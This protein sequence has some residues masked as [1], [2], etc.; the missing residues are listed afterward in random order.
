[1]TRNLLP[2]LLAAI[3]ALAGR[4][5]RAQASAPQSMREDCR[6]LTSAPHRLA[7]SAE[8]EQAARHVESRMR[9]IGLDH[10]IVQPF[11]TTQTRVKR[12][13]ITLADGASRQLHPMRPNAIFPPV[14][15]PEGLTA[16]IVHLRDGS[17]AEFNDHDVNGAIVVMDYNGRGW[18]RAFRLGARAIVFVREGTA[19]AEST[20]HAEVAANLPRFYYDGT[21]D[22]LP[23]A[24]TAT[25][26]SQVV[27]EGVAGHNVFGFIE[28]TDPVFHQNSD[29]LI[30]I[31]APL[32]SFG[33]VP[34]LSPGARQAA[35][36]AA[37]LQLASHF[38]ANPPRRHILLAFFDNQARCHLGVSAFYQLLEKE[39]KNSDAFLDAR[40]ESLA[41]EEA[42]L[43]QLAELLDTPD[44]LLQS[45]PIRRELLH[46][47]RDRAEE[48]AFE[49]GDQ[50]YKLRHEA[51]ECRKQA[52]A[53][54][55]EGESDQALRERI[56][57]IRD[58]IKNT[59]QP[60]K[61][62]W[63]AFRR[64]IGRDRHEE[65]AALPDNI[66]EKQN[67]ILDRIREEIRN[68]LAE[69][70]IEKGGNT[71]A[72]ALRD[73]IGEHWL[74]LHIALMLGDTTPRWGIAIGGDSG[75]HAPEDNPG[76]YGK[77]QAAF[78]RAH[79]DMVAAGSPTGHFLTESADQ[80][81]P[82]T[83]IL[84]AAPFFVHSGEVAGNF[85][86]YNIALATAQ[87]RLP[88][89]GTPDDTLDNLDLDRIADQT[90][91]IARL[92]SSVADLDEQL[93]GQSDDTGPAAPAPERPADIPP[94][95][96]DGQNASDNAYAV[97]DQ[98]GL[99]LRRGIVE[100]KQYITPTFN[101]TRTEGA[102]VAYPTSVASAPV[103][104]AIIQLRPPGAPRRNLAHRPRK[105]YAFDNFQ[106][107]RTN[108]EGFYQAGPLRGQLRW[109]RGLAAI[110]DDQGIVTHVSDQSTHTTVH[111]RLNVVPVRSGCT[112]LPPPMWADISAVG[113]I[114]LLSARDNARVAPE[115]G[116]SETHDGITSWFL[117]E[118]EKG[119]KLFNLRQLVYLGT[120]PLQLAEDQEIDPLGEGWDAGERGWEHTP[121]S[122]RSAVDLWRLNNS[123]IRIL[124]SRNIMDASL[125]E[126]HGRA[127]DLLIA[128][129]QEQ[130]P[131]RREALATSA[132]WAGQPV[133]RKIRGLFDDLVVAVLIL[134][135]ISVPFAFAVERVVIGAPTI[136][137]QIAWFAGIFIATFVILYFSHPA[138]AIAKTPIIIFL[139][140]AI[141]VLSIM[142]ITIIVRKFE[143]E[144]KALQGITGTV[145]AADVSRM[146]TLIA[147]MQ[148]GISTMRRRP[149]RTA[150]TATT[151][152]LLTFTILCFASFGTES[153]IVRLLV[154]P[155]PPYAGVLVHDVNW[156][157]LGPGLG[158]VLR[159]RWDGQA[160]VFERRWVCP[161]SETDPGTL[162]SRE[163]GSAPLAIK[164]VLGLEDGEL[165][166]RP[167]LRELVPGA[168]EGQV[169]ISRPLADA[170]EVKPGDAVLLGGHRL[171]VGPL[172][173]SVEVSAARDMDTSSILPVDFTEARSGGPTDSQTDEDPE[174]SLV[175]DTNWVSLSPDSVVIVAASLAERMGAGAYAYCLYTETVADATAIAEDIA[176]I[177]PLPIAATRSEGVYR[178]VLGTKLAASGL[179]DLF[180]PVLLGG[181]V[182]FGTMLGSVADR[183][184][185]IYTFSALGL[186]PRHVAT[187]FFAESMVYSLIGGMGGYLLAQGTLRILTSLAEYGLV[188]V[189]EMNM[190]SLNTIFTILIVMATVM[191]SA[192]YPAIKASKSA[193]PGLL[194]VWRPPEP[195]GDILD[196]VFPFTVSA[197]DITGVTSF[198]KEHFDNHS[199]T[200]LGHFMSR[201]ANL[202]KSE[203]GEL[204][205]DSW[206]TLA[207]FDLGVSQA[208]SLRSTPSEIAGIDEVRITLKRQSGQP[209]DWQ[210]LNKVFLDDLRQQFL[211][212]RS[213]PHD[214][215]EHYRARTLTTFGAAA[216][217]PT[218]EAS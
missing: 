82:Q 201:D 143:V 43:Q 211:I 184:K 191:V 161:R 149:L 189:P 100:S 123:R 117:E 25:I 214:T 183:E 145:H 125:A 204:G 174:Q 162:L 182:I 127:E 171:T 195:K 130:A 52:R 58:E 203:S 2:C 87:E 92:L 158:D 83:R 15:D 159:G 206:L 213:L 153:G 42:F 132:F 88:R 60:E 138:F 45:G 121:M 200:G 216:P 71:A 135:A 51:L 141:L 122:Q 16:P 155:N 120:G 18:M 186:A 6:A 90:R 172:L 131:L 110:F 67:V 173:D 160:Q 29:E 79:Q 176:R 11:R 13:T 14:T 168:L 28:G 93:S 38:H 63:N 23:R 118:R 7:G 199:D 35:N 114:Q 152:I 157:V 8:G 185:E 59:W 194:R 41:S 119:I 65:L 22:D 62:K 44:P 12:C 21:R 209:K 102:M 95:N 48:I 188:V 212:W 33:E 105:P 73:L 175:A 24:G 205:L 37:L 107:L 154:G 150:L 197:Y 98:E 77:V 215:M 19:Q 112:V 108:Q 3:T 54:T 137:R 165:A 133:Y 49:L 148:M 151:I 27:W 78:Q 89:E 20:H 128:A 192:I 181:L 164:G 70:A 144:I 146:S 61:D 103:A 94:D 84:S 30:I 46:R 39:S 167:D 166:A 68:R 55:R 208:F 74:A 180:F 190:S 32:D 111:H 96:T 9:E 69:I 34:T 10:V 113:Q 36:C 187:L 139:G 218:E 40:I 57:A 124:R 147:A 106:I 170:L 198:L 5:L 4:N 109:Y 99:S 72:T 85:G 104:G 81:L 193:N 47:C 210:R 196:L 26:H 66:V 76:L 56:A 75:L 202:T 53:L 80:S 64:A 97:A 169:R 177:C 91:E 129:R 207:P 140:F 156:N 163:D 178:H 134:L 101:R 179:G 136:Y 142:V 17:A 86:I 1:M 116:F 115:D 126:L 217:Q 31:A 50:M